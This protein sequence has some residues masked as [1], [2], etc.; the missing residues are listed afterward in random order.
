MQCPK[1]GEPMELIEHEPDVGLVGGWE[2]DCGHTE[3][4][5]DDGEPL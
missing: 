4:A 1:C 2:C 5:E 3:P